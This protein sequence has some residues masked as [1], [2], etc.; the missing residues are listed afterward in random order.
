MLHS[1]LVLSSVFRSSYT[2]G[3]NEDFRSKIKKEAEIETDNEFLYVIRRLQKLANIKAITDICLFKKGIEPMWEDQSNI[4]GGKWIIKIRKN[5]LEQMLF[6]KLFL[7]MG[8]IEFKTMEVNG[9]VISV[10]A[11]QV[12]LSLWTKTCPTDK[13]AI[14][15]EK[16]IRMLMS[17][18]P[19]II[20]SFKGN[21]ESLKDRSSF[22]NISREAAI[23]KEKDTGPVLQTAPKEDSEY[24]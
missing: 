19:N 5:K 13:E 18:K 7:A 9:I 17:I 10:R 2:K 3:D 11:N 12:I 8:L 20:V 22:R 15:Q 6:E 23:S 4:N 24:D 16:E 14:E 21:D 1:P